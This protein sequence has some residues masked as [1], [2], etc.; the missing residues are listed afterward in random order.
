VG[1]TL[2]GNSVF[3]D[4][5]VTS[6]GGRTWVS[7]ALPPGIGNLTGISCSTTSC[8]AVGSTVD[9]SAGIAVRT[10]DGRTW[11]PLTLPTGEK[12]LGQVACGSPGACVAV[13]GGP[14]GSGEMVL[15]TTDAGRSWDHASLPVGH[16]VSNG[17]SCPSP[18]S[19][20]VVGELTPPDGSPSGLI[21][22]TSD[23]GQSWSGQA[24][25]PVTS[26]L[27]GISCVTPATCVAVGG[28]I[29]P[30]GGPGAGVILTTSNG[31]GSWTPRSLPT[32][33]GGLADVSC[34]TIDD[35]VAT[36]VSPSGESPVVALSSDA[37]A[38]WAGL[39]P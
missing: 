27:S 15:T 8:L 38:S 32:G 3:G 30:R 37:G 34:S 31:G 4:V 33:V 25:A 14:S 28:G 2:S 21:F 36:G 26:G 9:G 35:C 1:G 29:G 22:S 12:S 17:I 11:T 18:V 24:I 39:V 6:D 10:S 5:V 13:G 16:D 7:S 23:G 20:V 19:C